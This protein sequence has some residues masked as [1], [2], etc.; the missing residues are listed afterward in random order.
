M[1][2][3]TTRTH[4]RAMAEQVDE[5]TRDRDTLKRLIGNRIKA[6]RLNAGLT[7]QELLERMR[8]K[9]I[10][11]I[12]NVER[13]STLLPLDTLLDFAQ[14]LQVEPGLLLTDLSAD[15]PSQHDKTMHEIR[16][17]L[18]S[19]DPDELQLAQRLVTA[20]RADNP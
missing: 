1:G 5:K 13:G 19:Y 8:H 2:K 16:L 10:E 6:A 11:S 14:A 4:F 18:A 3:Q 9:T 15:A 12:S 17:L 7:Q 20:I